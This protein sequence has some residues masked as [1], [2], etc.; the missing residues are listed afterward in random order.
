MAVEVGERLR[1]VIES[2]T[3]KFQR[4]TYDFIKTQMSQSELCDLLFRAEMG[5]PDPAIPVEVLREVVDP[6]TY[7]MWKVEEGLRSDAL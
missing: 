6:L 5:V 1:Q 2:G 4:E 3:P 7:E